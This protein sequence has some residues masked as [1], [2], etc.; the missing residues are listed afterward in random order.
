MGTTT[1]FW[2]AAFRL[3]LLAGM[4]FTLSAAQVQCQGAE[5]RPSL[6]GLQTQIDALAAKSLT[7]FDGVGVPLGIPYD[8]I[9]RFFNEELGLNLAKGTARGDFWPNE[10]FFVLPNCE[11]QAYVHFSPNVNIE[12]QL[13]GPFPNELPEC[14]VIG[15]EIQ[16]GEL[17]IQSRLSSSVCAAVSGTLTQ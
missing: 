17:P 5:A 9:E 4:F 6:E 8:G 15:T 7:V 12:N 1:E 2:R 11:D 13:I 3:V 14:L 16:S 10:L